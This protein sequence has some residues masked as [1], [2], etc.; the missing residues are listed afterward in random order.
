MASC[1]SCSKLFPSINTLIHHMGMFCKKRIGQSFECGQVG[2]SRT[3]S[4]K[5]SLRKHLRSSHGLPVS[6]E[7]PPTYFSS[8][9]KPFAPA[10]VEDSSTPVSLAVLVEEKMAKVFSS[11]YVDPNVPRKQV[12]KFASE[13]LSFFDFLSTH[14]S[15]RVENNTMPDDIQKLLT[16]CRKS[17]E[18]FDSEYKRLKCFESLGSYVKADEYCLGYREEVKG[19][20]RHFVQSPN[21]LQLV[22]LGRVFQLFF[23]LPSMLK[24]TLENIDKFSTSDPICNIIQGST[25][26][27]M[28][29]SFT[30]NKNEIHIPLVLY[31][32]DFEVNNPLGSH[33]TIHKLS[34]LYVS[35]PVLPKKYASLL[36]C[37]FLFALFHASDRKQ[38]GNKVIFEKPIRYLNM[39]SSEGIQVSTDI[40]TGTLKFHVTCF[41]GDNL[42]L[43]GVLGFVESFV[44]HHCCRLC[45]ASKED[46]Q[47]LDKEDINYLRTNEEYENALYSSNVSQTGIKERCVWFGLKGFDLYDIPCLDLLHDYLEGVCRYTL[48]FV[49]KYLVTSKTVDLD[50]LTTRIKQFDYGPDGSSSPANAIVLEGSN[51]KIKT[52]ASEMAKLVRYFTLIIGEYVSKSDEIWSLYLTLRELLDKLMTHRYY[53]DTIAYLASL[54]QDLIRKF[55][56]LSHESIKPKFHFLTH[57]PSII[58]KFGPLT[59][60]WTMRFE[61]KHRVG[62]SVAKSIASRVNIC[63]SVTLRNQ[64]ILNSIF[65]ANETFKT[66]ILGKKRPL[67]GAEKIE[68]RE[69]FEHSTTSVISVKWFKLDGVR[70]EEGSILILYLCAH[71]YNPI[72]VK[73]LDVWV[74]VETEEMF[75][76]SLQFET[77]YFEDHFFAYKVVPT[78]IRKYFRL[79]ELHST[80]PHTLTHLS[81]GSRFITLRISID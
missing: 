70:V 39:L 29:D 72:F 58:K 46:M 6:I 2:C 52:S 33:C 35:I 44:A 23:S 26:K 55:S 19:L 61:A 67:S 24:E 11:L 76:S 57:Y 71:T 49:V 16:D 18:M 68:F 47:I 34:A 80:V 43:N 63:K 15:E 45:N 78:S 53:K 3:Y 42:G 60:I 9:L 17:I 38:F 37:I 41:T 77:E 50:F 10:E 51:I 14:L 27:T 56:K 22:P 1:R 21:L 20:N 64:L 54:V 32:D 36:N 62:K 25:W 48:Q 28:T 31:Y 59:Q 4:M 69:N 30:R 75:F 12:Q 81:N 13:F 74:D 7:R 65:I 8:P 79:C 73:V 5:N 40:F 66:F